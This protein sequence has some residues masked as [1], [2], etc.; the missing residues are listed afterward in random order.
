[1]D[2]LF[3]VMPFADAERPSIGASLLK[4]EIDRLGFCSR[5]LYF[6]LDLAEQIG[7]GEYGEISNGIS[8]NCMIGE[9]FFADSVFGSDVPTESEYI[10]KVLSRS[11]PERVTS[12]ILAAR[13]YRAEFLKRC[14]E[15]IRKERP[16]IVAFTTTFHQTCACLAVAKE[17]KNDPNPPVVVFGGANCE[18]GMGQQLLQ[19]CPWIDYVCTGEGDHVFPAF[20]NDTLRGSGQ[21]SIPGILRQ[22]YVGQLTVPQVVSDLDGLPTPDYSDYLSRIAVSPIRHK[23]SPVLLIESSRGCW[24]GAKQHCTFCGLNGRTMNYRSKSVERVFE[25]ISFLRTTYGIKRISSVDNILDV[26]HIPSLFPRLRDSGLDLEMFYEVKANLRLEQLALLRAGGVNSIQP[27][28]ESFSNDILR[29][30]R[31]GCT[32]LQNLQLLRWS[33]EVGIAVAW[34]LLGGF[35]G[36]SPAAYEEMAALIPQLTHLPPPVTC[37]PIRLDRFSPL[38]TQAEALGLRRLRPTAAYYYCF[39]F[40][41][42]ELARLAYFFDF[43][44]A[45]GRRPA[46]YMEPLQRAVVNWWATRNSPVERQPRL[47]A[48]WLASGELIIHDTRPCSKETVSC[49]PAKPAKLYAACDSVQAFPHLVRIMDGSSTE[50]S[51]RGMLDGFRERKLLVEMENHYLSLAVVKNRSAL[52]AIGTYRDDISGNETASPESLLRPV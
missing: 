8:M 41:R 38:F 22:G 47:E 13:P 16:R 25:E 7:L 33:Q 11:A 24:W 14:A 43:D 4:A 31:K 17:L 50:A 19:S 49:F 3:I 30:M 37:T 48:E 36:E 15:A 27:G 40:G 12:S 29:R 26:K 34:N 6:N 10:D 35:P 2:V 28:I 20:V 45:D 18:G 39:P 9:W 32:G 44:Y 21:A 51:V 23:L 1:M 5:V 52:P 42:R 46:E